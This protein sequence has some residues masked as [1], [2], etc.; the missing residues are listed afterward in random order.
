MERRRRRIPAPSPPGA[1]Y[2]PLLS[3]S[4]AK[5]AKDTEGEESHEGKKRRGREVGGVHSWHT[6]LPSLCLLA[7][8]LYDT[9]DYSSHYS[10]CLTS[11]S[12][13][14]CACV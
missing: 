5:A 13:C 11:V 9:T 14:V 7:G 3:P 10:Q 6:L 1:N 2:V 8:K 4:L 12:V